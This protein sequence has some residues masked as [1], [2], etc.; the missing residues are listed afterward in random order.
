MAKQVSPR[1]K[2]E[3]PMDV[4]SSHNSGTGPI[5]HY[6]LPIADALEAKLVVERD[7]ASALSDEVDMLSKQTAQSQAVLK[8]IIKYLVDFKTKQADTDQIVKVL[9]EKRN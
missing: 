6:E 8:A 2:S 4:A 5:M 9:K 7:S 1:S 3:V